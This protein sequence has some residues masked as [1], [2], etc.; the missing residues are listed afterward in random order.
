MTLKEADELLDAHQYPADT[1]Q[2][3]AAHGDYVIDLPNGTEAFA[4]VFE[5]IEN[6][7]YESAQ[8]AREAMYCALSHK[9]V[10]RRHYS[11]RDPTTMGT[12]GPEQVSF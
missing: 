11:D 1:E 8:Q 12:F 3:I 2:L 4:D 5:R 7:T 6:E 9:A 10:G